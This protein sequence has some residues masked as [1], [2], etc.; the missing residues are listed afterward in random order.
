M[1]HRVLMITLYTLT[2][3]LVVLILYSGGQY[4]LTPLVE[5]PHLP[6]HEFWKANGLIGHTLGI[7]GSMMILFLL[8][9][10]LRKDVKWMQT[11]GNLRNW[12]NVHMWMG[13]TA[14]ILITFHSTGKVGGIVAISYW[15]MIAV[16]LSGFLGRYIYIQIPRSLSG[17]ELSL[18]EIEDW[19]RAMVEAMKKTGNVSDELIERI[20]KTLGYR[21]HPGRPAL[22]VFFGWILSDLAMPLR[23]IHLRGEL[24]KAGK[25]GGEE[26][27]R[28]I[29]LARKRAVLRR[30]MA[31]LRRAQK[32]LHYWH[33]VHRPFALVMLV[34]MLVHITVAWL[35]GYRWIF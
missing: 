18:G 26:I 20:Q 7:I 11:W 13:I 8:T 17:H 6:Q 19:D 10:V 1:F 32:A 35:F 29:S 33:V 22:L 2:A 5:R 12:L 31:F 28:L 3:L 21:T 4:Y 23:L 25:I 14:P 9:Y 24:R 27:R 15:S 16:A 34:I 30:R